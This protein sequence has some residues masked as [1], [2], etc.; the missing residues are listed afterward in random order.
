[1]QMRILGFLAFC[2]A[3][4]WLADAMFYN[5]HYS[6]QIWLELNQQAQSANYEVRRWVRF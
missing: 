4:L 1:M 5:G 6:N 2:A 3:A